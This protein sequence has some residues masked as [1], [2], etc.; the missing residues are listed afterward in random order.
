[1]TRKQR[2][3][4]RNERVRT[5]FEELSEKKPQWRVDALINEV[6]NRMFLA[7]RTIE[8][9]LRGEGS[10]SANSRHLPTQQTLFN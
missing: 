10:Y 5:L 3:H 7:P 9:I 8:A 1:M 6:A 2:L 4:K